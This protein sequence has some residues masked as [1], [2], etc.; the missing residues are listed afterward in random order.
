MT[1]IDRW[2]QAFGGSPVCAWWKD[3]GAGAPDASGRVPG[4]QAAAGQ[5]AG[6]TSI[7]SRRE[8]RDA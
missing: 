3:A 5:R 8:V 2:P 7:V 6:A 1:P 4:K